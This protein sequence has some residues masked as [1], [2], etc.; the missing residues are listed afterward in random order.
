MPQTPGD[1]FSTPPF[2]T[3]F[4]AGKKIAP[5]KITHAILQARIDAVVAL[6]EGIRADLASL[7]P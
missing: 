5:P 3:D 7:S 6:L 4:G 1:P 2:T